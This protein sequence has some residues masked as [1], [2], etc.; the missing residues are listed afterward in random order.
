[1][2]KKLAIGITLFL[3]GFADWL[4]WSWLNRYADLNPTP[5]GYHWASTPH[6][7]SVAALLIAG[8]AFVSAYIVEND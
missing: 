3:A 4:L 6:L 5:H 1:M 2:M 8:S 7:V